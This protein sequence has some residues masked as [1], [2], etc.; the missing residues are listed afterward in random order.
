MTDNLDADASPLALI[1][2]EDREMLMQIHEQ[3]WQRFIETGDFSALY[4]LQSFGATPQAV[5]QAIYIGKQMVRQGL[6]DK[7]KDFFQG[8]ALI[9]PLN[10]RVHQ[11]LGIVYHKFKKYELAWMSYNMAFILNSEDG[12]TQIYLG[13]CELQLGKK[14]DGLAHLRTGLARIQNNATLTSFAKHAEKILAA[15]ADLSP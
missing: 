7:A 9:E 15:Q 4:G 12:I 8:L 10:W 2:E 11:M 14:E 3:T 1:P 13:E 5:Q 6:L